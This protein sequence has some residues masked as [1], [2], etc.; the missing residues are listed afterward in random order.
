MA[1]CGP[2]AHYLAES[3]VRLNTAA[4]FTEE[5]EHNLS[6]VWLMAML[7]Q[8]HTLPSTEQWPAVATR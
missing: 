5:M 8:K 7:E 3:P 1:G 2:A 6:M 4:S